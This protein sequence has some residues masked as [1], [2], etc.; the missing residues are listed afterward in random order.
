M[1]TRRFFSAWAAFSLHG[2]RCFARKSPQNMVNFSSNDLFCFL[3][4]SLGKCWNTALGFVNYKE[5]T[6]SNLR[7]SDIHYTTN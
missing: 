4:L 2:R 6:A 5:M 7:H 1:K 3:A